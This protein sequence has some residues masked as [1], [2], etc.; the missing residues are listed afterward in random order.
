MRTRWNI[1]VLH[2]E[3]DSKGL[4]RKVNLHPGSLTGQYLTDYKHRIFFPLLPPSLLC[5]IVLNYVV[6]IRRSPSTE[7]PTGG[8]PPESQKH[9][10]L[11]IL[12]TLVMCPQQMMPMTLVNNYFTFITWI[13]MSRIIYRNISCVLLSPNYSEHSVEKILNISAELITCI[14]LL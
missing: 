3:L 13:F 2:Y 4:P 9:C 7:A 5:I 10:F 11:W 6:Q 8:N 12:S 1:A 14:F